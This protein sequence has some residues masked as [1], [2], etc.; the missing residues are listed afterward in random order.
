MK[1]VII[2]SFLAI[3]VI[4]FSVSQAQ[5]GKKKDDDGNYLGN[6]FP[7]GFHYN[8]NLIA[9]KPDFSCPPQSYYMLVT[10]DN[11]GDGDEG[12]LVESCDVG[13]ICEPTGT[14]IYGNVIFIPREQ[15]GDD[16]T[17]LMES[18][19][20]GPKGKEDAT[21]LEVIDWCTESFPDDGST[22]PPPGDE[23]VLR[24]PADPEGYAVYGRLAGKPGEDIEEPWVYLQPGLKYVE[25]YDG[26]PLL[27]LG[28]V[29]PSGVYQCQG[30]MDIDD[31]CY[32]VRTDST[33]K[34]KGG[35]GVQ[36][37]KNISPLFWFSGWICYI[38]PD[39][40]EAN[41]ACYQECWCCCDTDDPDVLYNYCEK[42]TVGGCDCVELT[43]PA[44]CTSPFVP[45]LL[46]CRNYTEEEEYWIFNI[47]DFVGYLWD[48]DTSG[49]YVV[50]I[51][52]Y[53]L[54]L[55]AEE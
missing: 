34:G 25:D 44:E 31:P 28:L 23:A 51:R 30:G 43:L 32:L 16:I 19:R 46:S 8:L 14:P 55:N 13:D 54:P 5:A 12:D 27:L 17:I 48:I 39:D 40:C 6:G 4:A 3:A 53:P 24:L 45:D 1:K 11:N 26:Q 9:K 37:A 2:A 20:K 33:A 42:D 36:K 18:G 22:P 50:Q 49:A 7:S 47:A 52:F 35:K 38:D 10:V 15:D 41:G 29:D 21:T